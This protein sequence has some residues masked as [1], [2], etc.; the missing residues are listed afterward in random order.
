MSN[1]D[2][3]VFTPYS[4][5][6]PYV[7]EEEI[8]VPEDERARL[9]SYDIYDK[10][11]WGWK[12]ALK[13]LMDEDTDPIYI[14]APRTIVESTA[15]FLLK[16]LQ[17][18]PGKKGSTIDDEHPLARFLKRERF[19]SRFSM[20]KLAG[21]RRGDSVWHLTVDEAKAPGRRLSLT[22]IDP[23]SYFPIPDPMDPDKNIGVA[24]ATP[25]TGT[26][27][28]SYVHR[29]LYLYEPTA[30]G[31]QVVCRD[32]V[33][34]IEGWFNGEA[35]KVVQVMNQE[36][37]LP[38]PIDT[39]PVFH[40]PNIEEP[41]NPYGSSELR[42]FERLIQA[43]NQSVT[44]EEVAL[45]LD[46]LGL[47]ATNAPP[48]TREDGTEE[49]WVIAPARVLE[50]Q[51]GK[52]AF[53]R[54]VEGLGSV[55][56]SQ[57]H[58]K[59]LLDS[60]YEGSSTFRPGAIDVQVAESGVALALKFLPTLAKIEDRDLSGQEIL[61]QMW[62]NWRIWHDLFEGE[63]SLGDDFTIR[64]TLG[65]KLPESRKEKLNELN[66]MYDRKV[67]SGAYYRSEMEKLGY[68]FPDNMQEEII[69]E[70]TRWMELNAKFREEVSGAQ[71]QENDPEK[72]DTIEGNDN[73]SNNANRPNE[74]A[75]TEA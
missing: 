20:N 6:A 18:V 1:I 72:N 17:I 33:L 42:G 8:W 57:D 34:E 30:S 53:F 4:T 43:I 56:P 44:D 70:Q 46:G 38:A 10:L 35:A 47:Y 40:F 45:A 9:A 5:V 26:D 74:S 39:V 21:V 65:S 41:E 52:D 66:N 75:G 59:F 15:H 27:G 67:I 64:A 14:P 55:K 28:K 7:T 12:N 24:L 16:G 2:P 68:V 36:W 54:R 61:D 29:V 13:L 69:A 60:I 11:F 58:I 48:P 50:L 31:R 49:P 3:T 37:V 22:P 25:Y 32:E 51:G 63:G 23:A 19:Y 71:G 62:W 73:K